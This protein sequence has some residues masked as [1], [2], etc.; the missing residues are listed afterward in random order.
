MKK[1]FSISQV[2]AVLVTVVILAAA[3]GILTVAVRTPH[4][5][6]PVIL[7]YSLLYVESGSMEPT[8]REGEAILVK[9]A[10]TSKLE[11]GEIIS[12][13]STDPRIYGK[14]NTHRIEEVID[15]PDGTRAFFTKGDAEEKRDTYPVEEDEV[16]GA[17]V[18][19]SRVLGWIIDVLTNRWTL[20]A[21][22]F[23]PLMA[24]IVRNI[25]SFVRQVRETPL[26][27]EEESGDGDRERK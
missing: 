26:P 23:I 9:G 14:L 17:L 13:Y 7:G 12:F 20:F 18:Y 21:V 15:R 22:I 27:G 1:R 6:A 2:I 11:A 24:V 3:I 19:H 4:G 25:I 8:V 10:D 5:K 16:L